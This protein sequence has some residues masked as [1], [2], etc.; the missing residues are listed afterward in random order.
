MLER[1]IVT[2]NNDHITASHISALFPISNLKS[3]IHD[4][5]SVIDLKSEVD[6]FEKNLI[7]AKAMHFHSV[8]DL[9]NAL[10]I[11]KSTV[12]RKLRK[13]NVKI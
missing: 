6:N 11:D 9:A 3:L 12:T 5:N 4:N 2:S 13:Y 1:I 7:L 10:N 8:S